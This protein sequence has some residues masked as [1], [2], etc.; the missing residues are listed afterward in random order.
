MADPKL[1]HVLFVCTGNLVRSVMGEAILK[2]FLRK[3]DIQN[4][5]VSSAG[6]WAVDGEMAPINTLVACDEHYVDVRKHL[7]T[8]VTEELFSKSDLILVMEKSHKQKI[9]N[10]MP[11][12]H[13]KVFMLKSFQSDEPEADVQDPMG[14]DLDYFRHA[15]EEIEFEVKRI[16]PYLVK[17]ANEATGTLPFQSSMNLEPL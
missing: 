11:Q 7:S 16:F 3:N 9:V 17:V 15:F 1:Y 4:I 10:N 13:R 14:R 5:H 12:I 2:M 8:R 6:T